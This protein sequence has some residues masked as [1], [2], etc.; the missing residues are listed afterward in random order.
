MG[1]YTY[2]ELSVTSSDKNSQMPLRWQELKDRIDEMEIFDTGR[3][4]NPSSQIT[5]NWSVDAKWYDH[6][7]DMCQLSSEFPEFLFTL[8]GEG[9]ES[10]D[11]WVTYYAGGKFQTEYAEIVFGKFDPNELR[12]LS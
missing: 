5:D 6:D 4:S 7:K 1:Y 9:E 8:S 3:C 2:Y 11:L 12:S 10:G